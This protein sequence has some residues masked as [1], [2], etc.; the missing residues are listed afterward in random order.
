MHPQLD[1][2]LTVATA[3]RSV[4]EIR[5]GQVDAGLLTLPVEQTDLITV[6]VL[7]EELLHRDDADASAG[8][9]QTHH[10]RRIWRGSRSCCSRP[11]RGRAA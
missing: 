10:A 1:V 9:A 5:A 4:E 11:G 6:P 7:R 3:G 2:R 8:E